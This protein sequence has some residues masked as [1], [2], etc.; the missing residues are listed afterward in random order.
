M[1]A[2]T[3]P[4]DLLDALLAL[5]QRS[6]QAL[7]AALHAVGWLPDVHGQPAWPWAQRLAAEVL[8]QEPQLARQATALLA[9]V[10]GLGV[11]ALLALR[12]R[13]ARWAL[14]PALLVVAVAAPW[15]ALALLQAPAVPTSWHRSPTGFTVQS[16]TQGAHIYQ[17]QCVRC[18][19]ADGKGEGPDAAGLPMWPPTL[20][21]SLLWKRLEGELFWRVRHGM[22]SAAGVQTMPAFAHLTDEQVW[23]VLDY[24]QAH[25]AG[26]LLRDTGAWA[27]PVRMPQAR[28]HCRNTGATSVRQLQGQRLRVVLGGTAAALPPDDPR[29]LTLWVPAQ[30]VAAGDPADRAE[31]TV[32][33]PD[34]LPVLAWVLGQAAD[35]DQGLQDAQGAQMLADRNGWLRA[36]ALPGQGGW[37]EDDLVCRAAAPANAATARSAAS[38][39][40]A[41]DGLEALIRRMDAEPVRL[42]RGGFPH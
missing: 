30:A 39:P 9:C 41:A 25:A 23:Q 3:L 33:E 26:Q 36:R 20:N 11:L 18:H 40:P 8:A 27:P 24:L 29:L 16:I 28:V 5:A 2:W 4:A 38:T 37:S 22:H 42:R 10:L 7:Q 17:Q 13:W 35:G 14:A 34:A 6:Q 32:Q 21:G 12:W 31:C 19:G 1:M 15:P